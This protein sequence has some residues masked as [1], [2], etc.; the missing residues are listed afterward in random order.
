MVTDSEAKCKESA[1][2]DLPNASINF[3]SLGD[4]IS[5]D[6]RGEK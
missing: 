3:G 4:L 2:Y 6:M 5:E 1:K